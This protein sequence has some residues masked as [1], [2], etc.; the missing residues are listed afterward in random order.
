MIGMFGKALS[1][2]DSA[3][4]KESMGDQA[5]CG[6]CR[7]RM[8]QNSGTES[9]ERCEHFI[10]PSWQRCPYYTSD[11]LKAGDRVFDPATVGG[12]HGKQF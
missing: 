5:C 6:N 7:N 9:I 10:L 3:T 2:W 1:L 4:G 12:A 11:L 8:P